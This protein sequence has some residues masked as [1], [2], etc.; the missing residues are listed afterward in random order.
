MRFHLEHCPEVGDVL[1]VEYFLYDYAAEP[2]YAVQVNTQDPVV[3]DHFT[4]MLSV[5]TWAS[6]HFGFSVTSI[7][8]VYS[9]LSILHGYGRLDAAA[10]NAFL[11]KYEATK[12]DR[13]D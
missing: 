3:E 9:T 11:D 5:D 7:T 10:W 6:R 1:V 2:E 12:S 8:D 13:E 4:S